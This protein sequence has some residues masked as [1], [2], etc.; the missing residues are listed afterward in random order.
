ME[1]INKT[2][3]QELMEEIVNNQRIVDTVEKMNNNLRFITNVVAV[4]VVIVIFGIIFY[5]STLLF[6]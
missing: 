2:P 3:N 5:L 4:N 6:G 1:N